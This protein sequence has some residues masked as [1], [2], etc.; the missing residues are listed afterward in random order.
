MQVY[1]AILPGAATVVRL[2]PGAAA[3]AQA[4]AVLSARARHR[5]KIIRW[6]EEHGRNAS[7]TCRH[8]GL[9]RSTFH[10]WLCR[11]QQEGPRGLEDRSRRPHRVRQR[12]WSKELA[13][14]VLDL[15]EEHPRWGKDKLVV[16]LRKE[17]WQVSTSMVGRILRDIKDRGLLCE[18]DLRDPWVVKRS[19]K[20]PYATR[21]P[22]DYVPKA[23]GD[24]VQA[25]TA[26][27]RFLPG[28]V[29]KHFTGRDVVSRWDVLDVHYRAT[30]QAAVG[31]LDALLERMPFEVKA[32]QVDGGSE[33]KAQ[34]EEEC[35]RRG[36]RLF[37]LPRR[38]PKL[39]G[40][41]ERA[42]RTHR[43]EF[44]QVIDPPDTL[45][46]LREGLRAHETV[47][48]TI[49]PHQALGQRTPWEFYQEWLA[50]QAERG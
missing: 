17:G 45:A 3:H 33:F 6:Y 28:E 9:S 24:L 10:L 34:F 15:R 47:Y 8:F 27:I 37:E 48:N 30:G 38:S 26:D 41:V 18:P 7:L 35:Q 21:K 1:G 16:L 5:L 12:T 14:A 2:L 42:H 49:R 43:E 36:I 40:H 46:E 19:P 22:P 31:F 4:E 32:I 13:Q 39:N 44:Y 25:D 29:Y 20:R 50:A 11:Y 23:P